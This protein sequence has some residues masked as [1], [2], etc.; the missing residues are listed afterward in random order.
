MTS[1]LVGTLLALTVAGLGKVTRFDLDR[2]FYSTILV[3]IASYYILFAIQ[4]ASTYAL[5]SESVIAL[6]FFVV[7]IFG[8]LQ[9]PCSSVSGSLHTV[10]LILSIL[11]SFTA[12]VSQTGGRAFV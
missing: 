2:S 4:G 12:P 3:V 10:F 11:P 7:A 9:F 1:F 5:I 8:A 6:A